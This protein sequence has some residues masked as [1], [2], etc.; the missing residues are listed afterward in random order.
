MADAQN[1]VGVGEG[2][3]QQWP[4]R[5]G[6][7]LKAD[8][9]IDVRRDHSMQG[10]PLWCQ[11]RVIRRKGRQRLPEKGKRLGGIGGIAVRVMP[12]GKVEGH[13]GFR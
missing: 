8:P 13:E 6:I 1:D 10:F 12:G 7:G 2:N 3:F 5:G 11:G 4:E 9:K